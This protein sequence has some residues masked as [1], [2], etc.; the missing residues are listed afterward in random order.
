MIVEGAKGFLKL[1]TW[2]DY[3]S[4]VTAEISLANVSWGWMEKF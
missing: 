2:N 3:F 1:I 4:H